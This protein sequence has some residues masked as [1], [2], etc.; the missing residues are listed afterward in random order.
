[1]YPFP[2]DTD[3]YIRLSSAHL[4]G[5]DDRQFTRAEERGEVFR[6]A[7]GVYALPADRRPEALHRLKVHAADTTPDVAISHTSAGVLHGLDML[8]A[9]FSRINVTSATTDRGYKRQHRHVHPGPLKLADVTLVD[10]I[11]TTCLERTAFDV[12]RTSPK[13]FP[14]A[15]AVLDSALRMGA[16]ARRMS[17]YGGEP[18]TGVGVA[19]TALRHANPLSENAGESWG[20]AQMIDGGL[21]TPR[22]QRRIFDK[23]GQ[24][25]ARV[26][27]DWVDE[28]GVVRLIGE[29]D[30][31]GKYLKYLR[32][33]EKPHDAIRREKVREGQLQDLGL[34]VV[35]WIYDDLASG[36]VV[37]RLVAQMRA[38]GL[39]T[40]QPPVNPATFRRIA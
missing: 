7:P 30:G 26:D 20:R 12:A 25:I 5:F 17:D 9:D 31:L 3:G 18:R 21:T 24:F 23:S 36:G 11:W 34:V 35:R 19:R 33:G 1:M 40:S 38:L 29:F 32:S 27:Y 14:A 13:G 10:G 28:N 2:I 37:P 15:L 22:L 4:L 6:V 8:H 39:R 16:A